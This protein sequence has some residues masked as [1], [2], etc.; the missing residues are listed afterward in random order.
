M[1]EGKQPD[2]LKSFAKA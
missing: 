2:V 1:C